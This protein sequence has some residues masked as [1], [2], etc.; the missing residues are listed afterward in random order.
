M[1]CANHPERE[2][3]AFCQNCGK[4]LCQECTRIIGSAVFCEPCLAAKLAGAGAPAASAPGSY[5]GYANGVSSSIEGMIPPPPQ[6]G[7]PNPILATILGLIPGVG[8][9]Y[10][11]QYVKGIVHLIVFAVLV[12]LAHDFGIFVLFVFGWIIYQAIE[13]NHTARARLAGTPLPNPFGLNDLGERLG[14]GKSWPAAAPY[15]PAAASASEPSRTP[16]V[17]AQPAGAQTP[18]PNQY[19][20]YTPP[21]AQWGPPASSYDYTNYTVPPVPPASPYTSPYSGDAFNNPP[22]P[23]SGSRLPMGA[24]WLI[25]LGTFFLIANTGLFH[26]FPMRHFVPFLLIGVGI[27]VF[28]H[29]MTDTGASLADDGTPMY[30]VRVFRALRGAVWIL[31]VGI[32]FLLADFNILSWSRSWPFFIIVA[33]LMTVLQRTAYRN[34]AYTPYPYPPVPPAPAPGPAAEP[35][36]TTTTEI[37]PT[38]NHDQEGM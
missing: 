4:P 26:G 19:P 14:F 38:K 16:D 3:V 35:P 10:N 20:P 34:A 11:G 29:R 36:A 1:N 6:S 7:E 22:N 2:R 5:S 9:M 25:G 33:G 24:I 37:V 13:A 30:Q 15:P 27:W 18:P 32:L 23:P 28:V 17:S 31:L 8:A 21:A 12:S